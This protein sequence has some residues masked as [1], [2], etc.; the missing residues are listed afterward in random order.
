VPVVELKL[1][2]YI[3]PLEVNVQNEDIDDGG[4]DEELHYS[5]GK[6]LFMAT[7]TCSHRGV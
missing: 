6:G 7:L 3:S 4:L 1:Y 2:G 5:T